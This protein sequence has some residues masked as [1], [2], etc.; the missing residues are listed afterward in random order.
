MEV[1]SFQATNGNLSTMWTDL[2]G[3]ICD[4]NALS[5]VESYSLI[6][7]RHHSHLFLFFGNAQESLELRAI[8]LLVC[9][10]LDMLF[11]HPYLFVQL[12]VRQPFNGLSI[13]TKSAAVDFIHTDSV[14]HRFLLSIILFVLLAIH[15]ARLFAVWLGFL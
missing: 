14:A 12:F 9:K 3:I 13:V 5:L 6:P 11:K 1:A 10:I 8:A 2:H 15:T 4:L 7:L